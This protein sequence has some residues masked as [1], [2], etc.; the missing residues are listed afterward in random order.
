MFDFG[1][2]KTAAAPFKERLLHV[3]A[4]TTAGGFPICA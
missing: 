3:A 2:M 1:T 4:L